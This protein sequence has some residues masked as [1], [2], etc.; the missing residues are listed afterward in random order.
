MFLLLRKNNTLWCTLLLLHIS[1]NPLYAITFVYNLRIGETTRAKSP[2]PEEPSPSVAAFTAIGQFRSYETDFHQSAAGML[3]TYI[4]TQDAW[5]ARVN[6]ALG[7]T[8]AR[9][10]NTVDFSKTEFDDILFTG[11]YGWQ[12]T[13]K[14]RITFSGHLG[15]PTHRD[16]IGNLV[17]LGTGH[18]GLGIQ[19]DG[20]YRISDT[21][22]FLAA[23]RFIHFFPRDVTVTA[24][25]VMQLINDFELGNL[26]DFLF[27]YQHNFGRQHGM[28]VG[29]N[30]FFTFGTDD[31]TQ[32]EGSGQV[33][34]STNTLFATYRYAFKIKEHLS[35]VIIGFSYGFIG[36]PEPLRHG[37]SATVWMTW[38]INF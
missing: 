9:R 15:V 37:N 1:Y 16:H 4:Y 38:G 26:V 17:Q 33:H 29:Y 27:T 5:Y 34:T 21:Q 18:I 11:G 30:P 13:D 25:N 8:Q 10:D 36:L 24:Q 12:L 19:L 7:R 6:G 20:S 28:S 3:G 2:A 14:A 22:T 35:A 23:T 32:P 31:I